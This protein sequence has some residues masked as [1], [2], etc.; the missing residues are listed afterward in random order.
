MELF[1]FDI[2][3]EIANYLGI[4][5]SHDY[6]FHWYKRITNIVTKQTACEKM[7]RTFDSIIK[8]W[9]IP[10]YDQETDSFYP[11]KKLIYKWCCYNW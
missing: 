8:N 5:I 4:L 7:G 1:V 3:T 6:F 2:S 11:M 10:I 9:L